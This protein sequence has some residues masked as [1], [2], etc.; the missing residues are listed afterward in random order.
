VTFPWALSVA[1]EDAAA[2]VGLRLRPRI[3]VGQTGQ[4][5]WL[6]GQP[7]DESLVALLHALPAT[8]RYE[9]Q[10][11]DR[12]RRLDQRIPSARLPN[13]QWQPL[14]SWLL[15]E[16]PAAALPANIPFAVALRLMRSGE[17]HEPDLLLTRINEFRNFARQAALVRL[18]RL[19]FAAAADG[20]VLVR[21]TPLP[22]LPG[23]RF[24]LH[25]GV[26]VPAGFAWAPGVSKQVL[27]RRFGASP[28]ALVLWYED[29]TSSRFHTEHFVPAAPSAVLATERSLTES[30]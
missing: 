4:Q 8:G 24:V 7:A 19:T 3:E 9:W 6:R 27:A 10:A 5:V 28:E 17:E 15:V 12:L 26:A 21:G 11:P 25:D 22:S 18:E 2:L 23:S 1:R 30:A 14:D 29:G 20:R 16:L 13:L